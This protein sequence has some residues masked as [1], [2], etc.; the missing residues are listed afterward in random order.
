MSVR[1]VIFD[2]DGTLTDIRRE[3]PEFEASYEEGLLAVVGRER[4]AAWQ[5]AKETV[6]ALS[7]ELA[8]DMGT[9]PAAPADADPYIVATMA[10]VELCAAEKIPALSAD[11]DAARKLRG[12]LGGALYTAAYGAMAAHFREDARAVLDTVTERV[13]H[14][15]VVS[16][17]ATAKVVKRLSTLRLARPLPVAGDARKFDLVEPTRGGF[18]IGGVGEEWYLPGLNRAV[19]PRRGRYF[20]KLASIWEETGTTPAETLVVGDIF[21]LDL[22]L[23]ALLGAQVHLVGRPRLHDYERAAIEALGVQGGRS[24]ALSDVLERL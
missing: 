21:E 23:P 22:A 3:G 11:T 4:R 5:T 13:R 19:R 6:R 8:W 20:D 1:L 12:D 14:V 16:N 17:S 15:R 24:E 10:L 7:P 9:G 18:G 2:F